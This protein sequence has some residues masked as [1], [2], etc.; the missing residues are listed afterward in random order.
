[1]DAKQ[2]KWLWISIGLSMVI[3]LVMM[4]LTFDENTVEALKNLNPWYLVLAF[5]LHMLAMCVWAVRIQVMCKALGYVIPFLHSLNMVCAGQ[6]I[7]SITPS[8][9]AASRFG[10]MNSTKLRC[11]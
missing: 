6:L 8:Q 4:V 10:F 5:G 1:M 7:A 3:L 11:Q 9:A 2:K